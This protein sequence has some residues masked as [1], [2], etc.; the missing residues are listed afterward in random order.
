MRSPRASHW[1]ITPAVGWPAGQY[2]HECVLVLL[3]CMSLL[4]HSCRAIRPL[5]GCRRYA[6]HPW[7]RGLRNGFRP[8]TAIAHPRV[9]TALPAFGGGCNL[10]GLGDARRPHRPGRGLS[11]AR[12]DPD[13]IAQGYQRSQGIGAPRRLP[14]YPATSRD[15]VAWCTLNVRA[16]ARVLSPRCSRLAASLR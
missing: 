9:T 2:Q 6:I 5:V 1:D 8:G 16:I 13:A 15:T 11:R 12:A 3:R 4:A 7:E 10:R 14:H